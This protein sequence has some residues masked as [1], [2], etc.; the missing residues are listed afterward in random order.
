MRAGSVAVWVVALLLAFPASA[1]AD[2]AIDAATLASSVNQEHCANIYGRKVETV[3]A[4]SGTI[5]EAWLQVSTVFEETTAPYLLFWRG[6]LAQCLGHQ[7]LAV[8]DLEAFVEDQDGLGLFADL[9]RQAKTRLTRLGAR[10][11]VGQGVAST[12]IRNDDRL[13]VSIGYSLGSGARE[14]A[15]TDG[16]NQVL[17]SLCAHPDARSPKPTTWLAFSPLGLDLGVYAFLAQPVGLGGRLSLYLPVPV[18]RPDTGTSLEVT[19]QTVGPRAPLDMHDPGV[20]AEV[21]FGPQFRILNS[22][23]SGGRATG[24]RI[25]PSFAAAFGR[26][27]PWAGAAKYPD[28]FGFLDAGF[29]ETRHLGPSIRLRGQVEASAKAVLVIEGG[30][31]YYIPMG[32][33]FTPLAQETQIVQVTFNN[34]AEESA[35][36]VEEGVPAGSMPAVET[37]SRMSGSARVGVLIPHPKLNIAVGPMFDFGYHMVSVAYNQDEDLSWCASGWAD[38]SCN[39]PARG[40]TYD[41]KVYSTRRQDFLLRFSV[42]IEFGVVAP[43]AK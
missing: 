18:P 5:N 11:Q 28:M 37:S 34:R 2:P 42:E 21:F 14:L 33:D 3:A 9:V 35:E 24:L 8:K 26:I 32:A 17:N 16:G 29:Y 7:E 30:F 27:V 36:R 10:G 40:D 6:V 20:T 25:E 43:V 13:E 41:R 22:V 19:G 15:C 12:Y 38:S 31:A 1:L 23:A 4:A 39:D